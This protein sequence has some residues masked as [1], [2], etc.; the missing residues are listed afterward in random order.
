MS[1]SR[2]DRGTSVQGAFAGSGGAWSAAEIVVRRRRSSFPRKLFARS[3]AAA[4]RVRNVRAVA[5]KRVELHGAR[6]VGHHDFGDGRHAVELEAPSLDLML[7][8][9][10]GVTLAEW[11]TVGG[12]LLALVPVG[13]C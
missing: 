3:R 2:C 10:R 8:H 11:V 12:E 4:P 7:Y 6:V 5:P 13:E 9:D 1:I